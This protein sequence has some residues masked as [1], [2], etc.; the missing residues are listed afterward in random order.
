MEG[1]IPLFTPPPEN[2]RPSGKVGR[3]PD[4]GTPWRQANW[5][6]LADEMART[7]PDALIL[8]VGAGRGDFADVLTEHRTLAL[9]V[10]PYPEVDLVCDLTRRNPFRPASVDVIVLLNVLEH[11]Y[12]ARA[13][14]A[15]LSEILKPGG[16]LLA[17]VPF[18]VKMH[19]T[20]LDFARYTH[21][22]LARF[23]A[24]H[25][26]EVER[27]EGYYDPAFLLDEGL[28]NLR[29]AVLRELPRLR[30]LGVRLTLGIFSLGRWLL[31]R[32]LGAAA[33]RV[34]PPDETFSQA[35]TG[36]QIVY[37]KK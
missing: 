36:Y 32:M 24:D 11:V 12:D 28:G 4:L 37:R 30:R 15:T 1:G 34:L 19:Q 3:G 20:P 33:H 29:W 7:P 23:A 10:Y 26:F 13:L 5:R 14:L 22:A 6:F 31:P 18:M 16:R 35:P 21:Y 27:L 17:A 2:I 9:E 8:D 25:G